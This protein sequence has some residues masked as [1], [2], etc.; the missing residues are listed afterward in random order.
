MIFNGAPSFIARSLEKGSFTLHIEHKPGD[1]TVVRI[2]ATGT[3]EIE[4]AFLQTTDSE[5]TSQYAEYLDRGKPY[6]TKLWWSESSKQLHMRFIDKNGWVGYQYRKL[7]DDNT[8]YMYATLTKQNGESILFE[9]Y[10]K[11]L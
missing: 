2:R 1:E 9:T 3:P 4:G 11:R 6:K 5:E 8:I 7:L 10:L